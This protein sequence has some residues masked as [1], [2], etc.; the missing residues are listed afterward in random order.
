MIMALKFGDKVKYGKEV[1]AIFIKLEKRFV[2]GEPF[3]MAQIFFLNSDTKGGY[4]VRL[5]PRS[6][7][8]GEW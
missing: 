8:K 5:V 4:S 6:S 1:E 7:I 3:K 2:G